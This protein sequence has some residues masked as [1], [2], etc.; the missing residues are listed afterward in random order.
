MLHAL[1]E[2]NIFISTTTACSTSNKSLPV[3]EITKD[4]ER[5]K[6]S[7][8][9]SISPLTTKEEIDKFISIFKT[10]LKELTSIKKTTSNK[11]S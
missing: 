11:N 10:K 8:R 7:L 5:A 1:E 4:E 9:I 3:Y 6:R 2:E